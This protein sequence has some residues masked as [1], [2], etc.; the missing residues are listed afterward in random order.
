MQIL[1]PDVEI[2]APYMCLGLSEMR[3]KISHSKPLHSPCF[4]ATDKPSPVS[5]EALVESKN[6]RRIAYIS[7]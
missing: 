3:P 6:R 2:H 1:T 5:Q 7:A 4:I